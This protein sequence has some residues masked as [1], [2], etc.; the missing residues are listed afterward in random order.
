MG[1]YKTQERL[2]NG[3]FG[4]KIVTPP[5]VTK[6][7]RRVKKE[8]NQFNV[9][10]IDDSI[11]IKANGMV[12]SIVDGMSNI[13]N[14]IKD[15]K[16]VNMY[17]GLSLFGSPGFK[18]YLFGNTPT[19]LEGYQPVQGSTA[20]YDGIG[21][22]LNTTQNH[23][24]K[25]KIDSPNVVFNIFTDGEENSSR[26]FDTTTIAK[27]ISE[28]REKGWMINFIG[29]GEDLKVK[30]VAQKLGIFESNV[31]NYATTAAGTEGVF[32]SLTKGM[33]KYSKKAAKG[34]ASNIGFFA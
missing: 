22:A 24:L 12:N 13:I 29:G 27:L 33:K 23:I 3:R 10:L 31:V 4:K 18:H 20:L 5:V 14:E 16:G 34:E 19:F 21:Y 15:T 11:S 25:S 1:T 7:T 6:R 32:E 26:A 28:Y 17:W 2:P 9:F 30:K 8:V